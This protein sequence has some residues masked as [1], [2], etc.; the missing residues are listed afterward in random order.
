MQELLDE[1]PRQLT[2]WDNVCNHDDCAKRLR[3]RCQGKYTDCGKRVVLIHWHT[4]PH[5]GIRV[6]KDKLSQGMGM[7]AVSYGWQP[8]EEC[9]TPAIC[10]DCLA[11]KEE[12]DSWSY[13]DDDD[14]YW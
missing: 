12:Q 13:E 7:W 1:A 3:A 14:W 5:I 8:W 9:N 11:E 2:L 4:P 6:D 10:G